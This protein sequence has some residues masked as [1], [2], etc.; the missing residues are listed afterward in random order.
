MALRAPAATS[1]ALLIALAAASAFVAA[2]QAPRAVL[3][4]AVEKVCDLSC[5]TPPSARRSVPISPN[6]PVTAPPARPACPRANKR[7]RVATPICRW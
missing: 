6:A 3:T 2:A 7:E 1:R 5:P 4:S